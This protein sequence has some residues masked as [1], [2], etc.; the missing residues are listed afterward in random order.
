MTNTNT[1]LQPIRLECEW[2]PSWEDA[3]TRLRV[4]AET[5]EFPFCITSDE[6]PIAYKN[7]EHLL[8]QYEGDDEET[9]AAAETWWNAYHQPV[10]NWEEAL[11][12]LYPF[13]HEGE[14]MLFPWRK[15]WA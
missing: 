9:R 10:N 15:E 7:A 6:T 5:L 14:A 11:R 12:T 8:A 3:K 2:E 13:Y 1:A 4:A